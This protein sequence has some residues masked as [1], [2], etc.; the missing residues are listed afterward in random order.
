MPPRPLFTIGPIPL[1]ASHI[2]LDDTVW[3]CLTHWGRVT[4]VC[5]TNL[6]TIC[7]DNGLLLGQRQA[8]IWTNAGI[9][10][11]GPL[12]TNFNEILIEIH[13]FSFKKIHFKMPSGKWQPF[14]L[15]LNVSKH[16]QFPYKSSKHTPHRSLNQ[17]WI[18][19][20]KVPCHSPASN[21][22]ANFQATILYTEF[23]ISFNITAPSP[24][25]Q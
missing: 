6:T 13:I 12:G 18:L 17:C 14:C 5:I 15:S 25:G 19:I 3:C 24:R 1:E 21:F 20:S 9:F 10:L 2:P 23:E 7:S 22:T 4:H 16:G 8:I 11:I